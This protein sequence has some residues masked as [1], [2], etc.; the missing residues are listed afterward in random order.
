MPAENAACV[1]TSTYRLQL[2]A[3]F[4]FDQAIEILDYLKRLGI[5]HVYCS[6][7]LQA[8]PGSMHGYDVTDHQTVNEELGG[9]AGH[10]RF[11]A[12]LKELGIGQVL[13]IVPNHMATGSD[14]KYW[15]DVLENGPSSRYVSWFDVD[16]QSTEV[17][18]QNKVLIPVLGDH[19][20]RVLNSGDLQLV[21]AEE[22]FEVRYFK[23]RFPTA[24]RALAIVLSK[25]AEYADSATL[26]FVADSL[27]RLPLP[28]WT[29]PDEIT[30]RH[31]DKTVIFELLRRLCEEQPEA[32]AAIDKA[33]EDMN[34]GPDSLDDFLNQQHYR[35]AF[36]RTADQELGY[37]R[38]FDVNTLIG[39]RVERPHVFD[40]THWRIL[41]WLEG[42]VL[43]GV[44]VDHPDGLR[45]PRKYLERLRSRAPNAWIIAE[46]ILAQG[47]WLRDSWPIHGTSG[48]DFLSLC[49]NL[50]V[51]PDGLRTLTE[52]YRAFT[53]EPVEF[54]EIAH[55]K[56]LAVQ[57]EALGSDVNRLASLFVEICESNRDRRDYTR[58]EIR[59]A[60]REVA[61]CF[62]VYRTYVAPEG[63]QITDE[64]KSQIATAISKAR[65]Q[66]GDLESGL[67]DFI[68]DVLSMR[69]RGITETEFVHRF[70]QFTSPVMAKGVE[71]TAF[72]CFNRMIELNEVGSSPANSGLSIAEFHE[73]CRKVQ[74]THPS[75]MTT[76]STHDTKRSDD[77]R[78]RLAVLSEIPDQWR[79]VLRRWSRQNSRFKVKGFPDRNAEYFLYQTMIGAWPI[80][81]DRLAAHMEKATREA[82]QQ[83]SWTQPN[84]DYESALREFI[85]S[86][87]GSEEFITALEGFVSRVVDAGRINSLAQ[88][89]IK[90]TAPGVPDTYQGGELWDLRLVD[91]DNRGP[92]DFEARRALLTELETGRTI[93]DIVQRADSGLPKLWVIYRALAL[94]TAHRE[95]FGPEATY[96][97][98]VASGSKKD[99]IVAYVR[100]DNVATVVPR[101]NLR[102]GRGWGA[103]SVTL[104]IGLWRNVLTGDVVEGGRVQVQILLKRF[105]V[106]L[107][108][109]EQE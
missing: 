20:G 84:K 54:W 23:H 27:S 5:S 65:D 43:D 82:K 71:D 2:N 14:N 36:W 79:V 22:R 34:R 13:D 60:I 42:G 107:F 90:L 21:R 26:S 17:K 64:D 55:N 68:E 91:P 75:T 73:Y 8:A 51:Y 104:P 85:D 108:T 105:A 7:Y 86:L 70:Q 19:Y 99:H 95:W 103:T 106:G 37:R 97:P 12:R 50:L 25:A 98:L 56:K 88:T 100:G 16:W 29:D 52:V 58:A 46:K 33:V 44:R 89:L 6:P 4:T 109:G 57:Q 47:E 81:I 9:E 66:R 48:Y 35:L 59:R 3:N 62:S 38:F 78:A 87:M 67:F 93:E 10:K 102:L 41:K 101:W 96:L 92:V 74:A 32:C 24:P 15:W 80:A 28:E 49:G 53:N 83:T 76:L 61:A 39:L 77:V 94:R 72:Y 63:D 31:R 69:V 1:P 18:L 30:S 45:D 11:C 40:A